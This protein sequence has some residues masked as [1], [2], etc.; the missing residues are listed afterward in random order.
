MTFTDPQADTPLI[1]LPGK[2]RQN[3]MNILSAKFSLLPER[4]E[5]FPEHFVKMKAKINQRNAQI[6]SG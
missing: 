2:V 5:A 4:Y 1:L 3:N 6:N